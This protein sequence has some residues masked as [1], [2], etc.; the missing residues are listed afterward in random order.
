[1]HHTPEWLDWD[2]FLGPAPL[3]PYH[4]AYHPFN[5]RG[6]WDFGTG[7]LGDIACHAMDAAFWTYDLRDPDRLV[8]ET[9][10]PFTETA[11][12][13]SR[14]EY[15][16]PARGKRPELLVVWRD[17]NLRPPRPRFLAPEEELPQPSGQV[18]LGERGALAAGI[19]GEDP[20]LYPKKLHDEVT[21]DPPKEVFPRTDGSHKEWTEACKGNGKTGSSFQD[22]SGPL[23]EMVL[24]GNLAVRSGV[25]LEWDAAAGRVTNHEPA[26]AFLKPEY[27][28]GWKL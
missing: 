5:W 21:N 14:I 25:P 16:F 11:P 7:A 23:T 13:S 15:H 8:A 26:N 1:M 6:W 2:L 10:T 12:A 28:E 20:R 19:Y 9:T 4:P 24:L 27:R 22:H 3:R 18:F 17:G